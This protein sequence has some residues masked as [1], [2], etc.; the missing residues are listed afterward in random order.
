VIFFRWQQVVPDLRG[1]A[2]RKFT[3]GPEKTPTAAFSTGWTLTRLEK[4]NRLLGWQGWLQRL[5]S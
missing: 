5:L 4:P 2:E 1:S 3:G